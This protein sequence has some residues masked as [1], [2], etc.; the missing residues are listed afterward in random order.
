MTRPCKCGLWRPE[1]PCGFT[2]REVGGAPSS[3]TVSRDPGRHGL[4]PTNLS[5]LILL[6]RRV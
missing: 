6:M 5:R 2:V 4:P 3:V 1:R